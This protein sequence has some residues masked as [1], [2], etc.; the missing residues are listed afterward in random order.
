VNP[1]RGSRTAEA[2]AAVRAGHFLHAEPKIFEDPHAILFTSPSWRRVIKSRL[3]C[4]IVLMP[5][6]E[7]RMPGVIGEI[8][9]RSRYAEDRLEA[10]VA[11][12]V[13]QYVLLGA[14]LDSFAV[15]RVDLLPR[16][17][18]FELDHPLT[19][20]SKRETLARLDLEVPA[21]VTLVPFD[22]ERESIPEALLRSRFSRQ[23]RSF[24]SWLGTTYYLTREA[25][26]G[27]LGG[28]ASFAAEGSE[29]VFDYA[30]HTLF[31]SKGA[32]HLLGFT[33]RRGEPMRSGLD[34]YTL[35]DE[36]RDLGL[37]LVENLSPKEQRARY[38]AN[39]RDGLD[40][41]DG[42][43]FACARVVR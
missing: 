27:T 1:K 37:L 31:S 39:R 20:E 5:F 17:T 41:A 6:F 4:L 18:V 35:A 23:E 34:P 11:D 25:V 29:I 28:L 21:N 24:L 16:L 9:G 22:F 36:I 2:A 15:R 10:A 38:F 33:A 13:T 42:A 43:Y 12:G 14:G 40:T 26:L 7:W 8:L 19:Q 30:D 32:Q 3:L